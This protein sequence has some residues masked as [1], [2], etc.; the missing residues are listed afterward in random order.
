M[1]EWMC[2]KLQKALQFLFY[3]WNHHSRKQNCSAKKTEKSMGSLSSGAS[4][5][6]KIHVGFLK[7]M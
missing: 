6:K 5:K 2:L 1:C 4:G 7:K 3:G